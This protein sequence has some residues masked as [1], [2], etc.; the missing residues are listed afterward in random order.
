M[1]PKAHVRC[2]DFDKMVIMQV[3]PVQCHHA[4]VSGFTG[5]TTKQV[6]SILAKLWQNGHGHGQVQGLQTVVKVITAK[7][8][9]YTPAAR[10]LVMRHLFE[11][12]S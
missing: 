10:Y 11:C 6:V 1:E 2:G 5:F 8:T 12:Q 9:M 3:S 4:V 7:V